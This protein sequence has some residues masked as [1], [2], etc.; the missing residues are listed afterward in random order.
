MRSLDFPLAVMLL[1]LTAT[2]AT[3]ATPATPSID[4]AG[5]RIVGEWRGTS[6]CANRELAPA[7]KD[8]T[9]RYIFSGPIGT[10]NTYH[11]VAEKL[12]GTDYQSMGE[13]DLAYGSAD[14]TWKNVF[15]ARKCKQ[16][17]WRFRVRASGL[18]GALTTAEGDTLRR[19]SAVRHEPE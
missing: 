15:D 9:V 7:C 2:S 10:T 8:E 16:C 5:R 18:V 1:A 4:P 14:S 17:A 6:L 13:M 11:L 3:S 19:V 12:V